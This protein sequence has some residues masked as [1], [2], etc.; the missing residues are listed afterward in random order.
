MQM[1]PYL[2]FPGT[3]AEAFRFYETALGG[4]MVMMMTY[5]ESPMAEHATPE[6]RD[7]IMHAQI[8]VGDA[9]LMGS[10]APVD[11]RKPMSG[12]Y[13]S[14]MPAKI[15]EA[16]RLFAALSDGGQVRMPLAPTFWSKAFGMVADRFGTPW[17]INCTE[18]MP[19]Q[20]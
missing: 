4:E 8:K 10:D 13:V 3:C 6:T 12:F 1:I 15:T 7:T 2:T 14:L 5:G 17:M 9:H 19:G 16:E 18:G 20:S 11:M